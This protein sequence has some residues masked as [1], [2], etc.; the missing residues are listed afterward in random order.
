MQTIKFS[1][2]I[3]LLADIVNYSV[4]GI[5]GAL[6]KGEGLTKKMR[7]I[8]S[9]IKDGSNINNLI[10]ILSSAKFLEN[11]DIIVLPSKLIAVLEKRFVYGLTIDNYNR[12][13]NN[14]KFA[15]KILKPSDNKPLTKKDIIGLDKINPE[16]GIGVRYSNNPNQ[17]AFK[18]ADGIK[19]NTGLKI[20]V[21]ITDSDSGGKKGII[22][23][24]CPTIVATPIGATRGL[25]LFYCMR[26]ATAAEMIRNNTKNIPA[27]VIEPYQASKLRKNIGEFR[28]SGFIDGRKEKDI[29]L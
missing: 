3:T 4:K 8:F 23:I 25:G 24:N 15:K 11:G 13:I 22:L 18:I 12:C 28:Y 6:G 29:V 19:K 27:V 1:K 26:V 21:V 9:Y 14:L 7:P 10:T 5:T 16:K 17:S 2:E 20:D